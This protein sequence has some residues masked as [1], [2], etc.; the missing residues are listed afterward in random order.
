M[1]AP[2]L[3]PVSLVDDAAVA[4]IV[5]GLR[6]DKP[7]K[8]TYP[9]SGFTPELAGYTVSEPV[10]R[11]LI[12]A[13][14]LRLEL[15][16]TFHEDSIGLKVRGISIGVSGADFDEALDSLVR[17]MRTYCVE[18]LKVMHRYLS[19]HQRHLLPLLLLFS[20]TPPEDHRALLLESASA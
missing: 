2:I 3:P 14:G 5:D 20:M 12:A 15:E 6:A 9:K 1:T 11:A 16:V 4:L 8:V 13:A 7:T 10:L 18:N 17:M 19:G